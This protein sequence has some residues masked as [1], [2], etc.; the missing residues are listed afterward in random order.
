MG[1]SEGPDPGSI[2]GRETFDHALPGECDGSTA[3]FETA[4]RG[5][6]PRSGADGMVRWV[7][8]RSV[9]EA[10]DSAKVEDQVRLLAGALAQ[11]ASSE[12][13]TFFLMTLEPDGQA[14]ACKAVEAGS[15]PASVFFLR[16]D[17]LP[18]R[19]GLVTVAPSWRRRPPVD[20]PRSS[21]QATTPARMAIAVSA[22]ASFH[23]R[24]WR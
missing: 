5:S 8:P 10:R 12:W 3:V 21:I 6:I 19:L 1:P 18:G 17:P 13:T 14:T 22:I 7:C 11:L 9:A 4:G 24:A 20:Y 16:Q 15:I 2:P 23:K